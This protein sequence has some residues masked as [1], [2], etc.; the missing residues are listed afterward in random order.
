M[1]GS[2]NIGDDEP[3]ASSNETENSVKIEEELSKNEYQIKK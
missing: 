1:T 2:F 3:W